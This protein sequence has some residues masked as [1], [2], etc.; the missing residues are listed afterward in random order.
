MGTVAKVGLPRCT[1]RIVGA[2]AQGVGFKFK[3][4]TEQTC[5]R[6]R[7]SVEMIAERTS[8]SHI[9]VLNDYDMRSRLILIV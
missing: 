1:G 4:T 8:Q 2:L 3:T 9:I 6:H 5:R 7:M